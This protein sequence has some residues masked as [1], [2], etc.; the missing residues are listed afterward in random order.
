VKESIALAYEVLDDDGYIIVTNQTAHPNLEFVQ[1][2][3]S[4]FNNKPLR[5]TMR[6]KETMNQWLE[7]AGFEVES[8]LSDPFGFY[9]VTKA[10]K[11]KKWEV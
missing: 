6:T 7:E 11:I 4:D 8:T 10:H 9:S 1:K 5:M 2:V 3:F